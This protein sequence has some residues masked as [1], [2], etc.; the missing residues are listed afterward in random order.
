MTRVVPGRRSVFVCGIWYDIVRYIRYRYG[1]ESDSD[2][3]DGRT[4]VV[5]DRLITSLSFVRPSKVRQSM[6]RPKRIMITV[7]KKKF[8]KE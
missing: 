5:R 4:R 7:T 3:D 2:S 6:P 8:S 1:I